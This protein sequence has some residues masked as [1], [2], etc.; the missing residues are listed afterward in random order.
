MGAGP[1]YRPVEGAAHEPLEALEVEVGQPRGR[2]EELRRAELHGY[3]L[4]PAGQARALGVVVGAGVGRIQAGVG[5]IQ[6]VVM[7]RI[8]YLP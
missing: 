5:R 6:A 7:G 8:Q 4:R 1:R 3:A 2:R